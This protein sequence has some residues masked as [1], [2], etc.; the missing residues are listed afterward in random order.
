MKRFFSVSIIYSCF[1]WL[2]LVVLPLKIPMKAYRLTLVTS[3][4]QHLFRCVVT[5]GYSEGFCSITC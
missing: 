3:L 1:Y 5:A 2:A 4:P